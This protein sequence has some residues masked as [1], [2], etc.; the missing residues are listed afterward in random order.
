[1]H[2]IRLRGPWQIEPV[3]E[4]VRASKG[5]LLE[6]PSDLPPAGETNVP[7]DWGAA[8]GN[9][10]R[11]RARFIRRFGLPTNLEPQERVFLVMGPLLEQG[12]VELNGVA[13]G[14]QSLIDGQQRY[15]VTS[16]LKPRNEL[17]ICVE[18]REDTG[19]IRGEVKLEIE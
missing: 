9:T 5:E 10:F 2:T 19:G 6:G 15:D 14:R 18:S 1:M 11:G 3:S 8:L 12:S 17:V 4:F 16:L 13:L 7:G